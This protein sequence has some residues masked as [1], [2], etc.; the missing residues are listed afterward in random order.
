M[1]FDY[2]RVS[3]S[4]GRSADVLPIIRLLAI[5]VAVAAVIAALLS[6]AVVTGENIT[7]DLQRSLTAF[8]AL[9]I[10]SWAGTADGLRVSME[11][12]VLRSRGALSFGWDAIGANYTSGM[13]NE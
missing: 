10:V 9:L 3:Y 13:D 2:K 5:D 12:D 7:L 8:S 1:A 6:G 4:E 11:R